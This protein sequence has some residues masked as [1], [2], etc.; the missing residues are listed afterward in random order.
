MHPVSA[1]NLANFSHFLNHDGSKNAPIPE[2]FIP[3]K[4][5]VLIY[6]TE[7]L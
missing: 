3:K 4:I 5:L 7:M 6:I 1:Q 2:I